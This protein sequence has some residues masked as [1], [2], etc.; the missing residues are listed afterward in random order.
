MREV[1]IELS[2]AILGQERRLDPR[3]TGF[4]LT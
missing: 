2:R 3:R 1:G 4:K